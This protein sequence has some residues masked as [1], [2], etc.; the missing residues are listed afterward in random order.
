MSARAAATRFIGVRLSRLVLLPS[1]DIFYP[2]QFS[3]PVYHRYTTLC[4]VQGQ[5]ILVC[6]APNT[7]LGLI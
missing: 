3:I 7:R 6:L 1:T 2:R 5:W 4:T